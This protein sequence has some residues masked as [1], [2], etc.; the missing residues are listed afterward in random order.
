MKYLLALA[1]CALP[2]M[3]GDST[4]C[5]VYHVGCDDS[6]KPL[7]RWVKIETLGTP[8]YYEHFNHCLSLFMTNCYEITEGAPKVIELGL[9]SGGQVAWR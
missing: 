5:K 4:L 9:R 7:T 2:S 3:A 6:N 1:L 8:E